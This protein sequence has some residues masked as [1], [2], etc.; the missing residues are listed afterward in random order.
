LGLEEKNRP[1]HESGVFLQIKK[2]STGGEQAEATTIVPPLFFN[3]VQY[4]HFVV[5]F[6]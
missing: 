1:P 2:L 6:L 3:R 5:G 4:Y